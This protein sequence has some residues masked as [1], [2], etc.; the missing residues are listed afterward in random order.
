MNK[1]EQAMKALGAVQQHLEAVL[2]LSD[3]VAILG[4]KAIAQQIIEDLDAVLAKHGY[5]KA[6]APDVVPAPVKTPAPKPAVA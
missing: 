2:R 4:N 5:V 6:S 1:H 3:A